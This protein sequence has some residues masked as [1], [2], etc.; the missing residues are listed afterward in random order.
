MQHKLAVTG[1]MPKESIPVLRGIEVED[2]K[3]G[4][5]FISA[6]REEMRELKRML[7]LSLAD[8][9]THEYEIKQLV[10]FVDAKHPYLM[11]EE[12]RH[13]VQNASLAMQKL[14]P[15]ERTNF[16]ENKLYTFLSDSEVISIDGFVNFRLKEYKEKLYKTAEESAEVYL[17]EK[18]YEEFITL[19]KY[20]VCMQKPTEPVLHVIL[21]ENG[22][23]FLLNGEMEDVTR[24]H[25]A[26]F[27]AEETAPLSSDDLLVSLLITLAPYELIL[28]AI[29]NFR[30]E[31]VPETIFK[32]FGSRVKLCEM[33]P[34]C[35]I[36]Q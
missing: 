9:I 26:A 18:E 31:K 34:L 24:Q 7:A 25:V 16:I 29:Q 27:S 30:N 20:F 15:A 4:I 11:P 10:D 3:N 14:P 5:T 32:V 17:A 28:H 13:V 22:D 6:S 23:F 8:M 21:K 36:K 12:R 35:K 2:G 19:L 33:C 1:T